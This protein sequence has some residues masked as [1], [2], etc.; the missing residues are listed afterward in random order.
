MG[1]K[2]IA[3]C[4][5]KQEVT[6]GPARTEWGTARWDS[7]NYMELQERKWRTFMTKIWSEKI[8]RVRN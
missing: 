7:A 8:I 2:K 3:D 4:K 1:G 5:N 6:Y